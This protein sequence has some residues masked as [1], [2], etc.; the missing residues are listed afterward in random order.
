MDSRIGRNLFQWLWPQVVQ[1]KLDEFQQY[2]NCHRVR[3]Q[4]KKSMPSGA[5]PTDVYEDPN[6]YG[7]E[8]LRIPVN[9]HVVEH[10]RT[11]IPIPREDSFRFVPDAF[12]AVVEAI[13]TEIGRPELILENGWHI[14]GQLRG[15]LHN[16]Y[17]ST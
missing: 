13:Y 11:Q 16:T 8:D 1:R 14:Y 2:W 5:T 3:T 15:L 17:D 10:L 6:A 9:I 12:K 4:K 7:Y